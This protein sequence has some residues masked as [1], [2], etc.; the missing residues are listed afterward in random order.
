MTKRQYREICEGISYE[1]IAGREAKRAEI[2]D[3]FRL[4]GALAYHQSSMD[5]AL[6]IC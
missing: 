5:V 4:T 2:L 1:E 6:V 3:D